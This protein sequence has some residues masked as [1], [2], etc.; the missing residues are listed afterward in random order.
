MHSSWL[1][2]WGLLDLLN[3]TKIIFS[4]IRTDNSSPHCSL[5]RSRR[6]Q[7]SSTLVYTALKE[8]K[9]RLGSDHFEAGFEPIY[10]K[11]HL[12]DFHRMMLILLLKLAL[13]ACIFLRP[14]KV[15]FCLLSNSIEEG[16]GQDI[17]KEIKIFHNFH[18]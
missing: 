8:A 14:D 1:V 11:R 15:C 2:F 17:N 3:Y 5:K 10:K 4:S 6:K 13:I 7:P 18:R 16:I 9:Q 12:R